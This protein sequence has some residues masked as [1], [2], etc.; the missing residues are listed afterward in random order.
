MASGYAYDTVNLKSQVW[1]SEFDEDLSILFDTILE[2]SDTTAQIFNYNILKTTQ[3]KLLITSQYVPAFHDTTNTMVWL[4]DSAFNIIRE[5]EFRTTVG[6]FGLSVVELPSVQSFHIITQKEITKINANN[7]NYDTIIWQVEDQWSQWESVGGSKSISDSS[8]IQPRKYLFLDINNKIG[9]NT[10]LYLRNKNGV[11]KDSILIGDM[12]KSYYK[13]SENNFDFF[14]T[15]SIFVTGSNFSLDSSITSKEDNTVFLWNISQNG[16]INWQK[17][18]SLYGM[19][20]YVND[21]KKTIDGGCFLVGK[22]WDWHNYFIDSSDIFFL[23][24]DRNGN[25]CGS[26]GINKI[27]TQSEILVYPNPAKDNLN[28]DM[29]MYKDFQLSVYN[30]MGQTIMQKNFISGNNTINIGNFKPGIY[31]Y[32]LQNKNGKVISGKFVKE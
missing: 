22:A 14:T 10:Y 29:G 28:F 3:N 31:F 23:K 16:Q 15:D 21:I 24:L 13:S 32:N 30:Q 18:Y 20:F 9:F 17:Y 8:Y 7:L 25:V 4:I 27:I 2:N 5:N 11:I 12:Q 1:L 6:F 19:T 26:V